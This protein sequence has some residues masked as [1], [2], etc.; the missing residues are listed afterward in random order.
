MPVNAEQAADRVAARRVIEA[1]RCGVPS[2]AA[3]ASLG[4]AQ[5]EIEDKFNEM[6][7]QINAQEPHSRTPASLLIGGDFGS[8][9]SHALEHLAHLALNGR[10]MVSKVVISKETPLFDPAKVFRAAAES[11]TL[12]GMP[13][14]ALDQVSAELELGSAAYADLFRWAHSPGAALNQRFAA[15]L[16]LFERLLSSDEEFIQ[17]VVRFWS[18]DPIKVSDLRRRLKQT[19][20]PVAYLFPSVNQRDLALQRF[21]FVARLAQ[22]AGYAGWVIL[23]DEVELIGRYSI[24]QRA[25]S[26]AEIARW[27]RASSD[28]CALGVVLAI[29]SDFEEAVL[30]ARNDR[31]LVPDRLR[32]KGT[33]AMEQLSGQ[34]EEGMSFISREMVRLAPP[35]NAEL[36][37][38]YRRLRD[39]HGAA[40]DWDPPDVPGLER[41]LST[42]M[43][44]YVRA[45]IN[46]WDLVRLDSSYVPETQV[47]EVASDY[48]ED[49]DLEGTE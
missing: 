9:K 36:D 27:M 11:A 45:W 6:L 40:F 31:K 30:S 20:N 8:G 47:V 21:R 39:I 16:Y 1:L 34:A 29:T 43:R 17:A 44:Q 42:R 22:A 2:R 48:R 15:S 18:G 35:D 41:K 19:G 33:V 4:S 25:K 7:N 12:P 23:L 24:L 14:V 32:S 10:F 37:R 38:L 13:R 28:E 46:E 49:M 26:Y 5:S 3:V